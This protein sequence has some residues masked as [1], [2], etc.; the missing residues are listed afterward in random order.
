MRVN[1]FGAGGVGGYLAAKLGAAGNCEL[2]VIARG[3]H[4]EAIRADGLY[5][6]TIDGD[7]HARVRVEEDPAAIG[8]VDVVLFTVKT[9][10]GDAAVESLRPLL[11]PDTVVITLQNGVDAPGIVSR[12]VPAERVFPGTVY[13]FVAI[14]SPGRIVHT[15][16]PARFIFGE[17]GGSDTGR[18]K[19]IG[20]LL[21]DAGITCIVPPVIEVEIWRKFV[22]IAAVAGA[23]A[24]ARSLL[25]ELWVEPATAAVV[26]ALATEAAAVGRATGVDLP[27]DLVAKFLQ[28]LRGFAPGASSSLHRDLE[29]GRPSELESIPGAIVRLA[30]EHG[31]DVP[32]TRTVYGLLLPWERQNA[33]RAAN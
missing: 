26:E 8:P 11:G 3:A 1:V 17:P 23:T 6:S 16:V 14:E 13:G 30:A 18:A 22:L 5:L 21:T 4:A 12:V 29:A 15:T 32:V 25:A 10:H 19:Q 31:V 9:Q 27:D 7:A 24:A 28:E 20:D 33:A 2:S